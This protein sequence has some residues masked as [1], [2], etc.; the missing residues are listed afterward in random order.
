M[1]GEA[2]HLPN[3]MDARIG[4]TG[5]VHD[6]LFPGNSSDGIRQCALDGAQSRLDLPSSEIGSVIGN[7]QFEITRQ[8]A[9]QTRN[10]QR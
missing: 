8:N 7:A 9:H 6:R 2:C 5:A 3:G 1:G 4:T 10:F